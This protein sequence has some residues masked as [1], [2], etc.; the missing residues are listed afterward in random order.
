MGCLEILRSCNPGVS[1]ILEAITVDFHIKED[2]PDW[3]SNVDPGFTSEDSLGAVLDV[4]YWTAKLYRYET[5][6]LSP[7]KI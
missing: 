4:S 1:Q 5:I 7:N 3:K 6:I 2:Y